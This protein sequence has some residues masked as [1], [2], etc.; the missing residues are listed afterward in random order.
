MWVITSP[1]FPCPRIDDNLS[2]SSNLTV[3]KAWRSFVIKVNGSCIEKVL[4]NK[5]HELIIYSSFRGQLHIYTYV[6]VLIFRNYACSARI[7][8]FL[9]FDC[10]HAVYP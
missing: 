10:Q 1:S 3:N 4:Y 6:Q 9:G 5:Y 2:L 8:R 7:I